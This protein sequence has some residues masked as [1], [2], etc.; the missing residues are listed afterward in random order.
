MSWAVLL[1]PPLLVFGL[2]HLFIW[3]DVFGINRLAHW[4]RVA[5]SAAV[6]HAVLATGFLAYL[7]LDYRGTLA[8]EA[9]PG[10]DAFLFGRSD[11]RWVALIFDTAAMAAVVGLFSLLDR[12]GAALPWPVLWTF[13]LIY[14]V[15]SLQWFLLGGAVGALIGR[16]WSAMKTGDD[17]DWFS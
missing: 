14:G 16:F 11:F 2:Y 12:L 13:V 6:S 4:K 7:Y 9:D 5:L 1:L 8:F 17:D 15:G 10:F 3:G